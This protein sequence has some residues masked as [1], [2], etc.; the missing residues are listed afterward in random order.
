MKQKQKQ[1]RYDDDVLD[2]SKSEV[3]TAEIISALYHCFSLFSSVS[4]SWGCKKKRSAIPSYDGGA[5]VVPPPSDAGKAQASSPATPL[6]FPAT[7]SDEKTKPSKNKTSLKRKREYYLKMIEDLTKTKDSINQ[8]ID[9]MKRHCEQLKEF[10][11][12]LKAREKE[13]SG[14]NGHKVE[15]KNP[16]LENNHPIQLNHIIKVSVNSLAETENEEKMKQQIQIPNHHNFGVSQISNGHLTTSLPVASSSLGRNSNMGPLSIPDL[17]L[18][19][20]E[21]VHVETCQ[22]LDEAPSNNS[23]VMAAQARQRR[24]QIFRLKKP[25]GNNNTKQRQSYNSS[26]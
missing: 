18:S 9:H 10:N 7:E 8:E 6:S 4:Y 15:C 23:K 17:N 16:N 22:P 3:E 19:I 11:I 1:S 2:W 20:E 21:S 13:L 14:I 26:R 24:I 12:K 25:V 5:A